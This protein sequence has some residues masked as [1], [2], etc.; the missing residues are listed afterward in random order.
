MLDPTTL[1]TIE[2]ALANGKRVEVAVEYTDKERRTGGHIVVVET[3]RR[4]ISRRPKNG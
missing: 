3:S 2:A 4:V 1:K